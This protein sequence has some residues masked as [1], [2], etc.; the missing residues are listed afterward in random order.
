MA[1]VGVT[2]GAPTVGSPAL[3]QRHALVAVGIATGAP[4]L[5]T[6]QLDPPAQADVPA[7]GFY[8]RIVRRV[9]ALGAVGI[10]AGRPTLGAPAL[11]V[12]P[13]DAQIAAMVAEQNRAAQWADDEEAIAA[14]L[15]AA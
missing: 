3:G 15:L 4:Q 7:A 6:P 14:L 11:S 2:T 12:R 8:P 1:A 5:G 10:A 13:S 9:V